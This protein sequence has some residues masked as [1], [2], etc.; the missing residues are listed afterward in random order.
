[1]TVR[2]WNSKSMASRDF[3]QMNSSRI[4]QFLWQL[5]MGSQEVEKVMLRLF[6]LLLARLPAL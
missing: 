6:S 1:M 4:N 3:H 5:L 2:H